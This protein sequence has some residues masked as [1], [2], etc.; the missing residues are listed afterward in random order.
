MSEERIEV[1]GVR[2]GLVDPKATLAELQGFAR[3]RGGWAQLA[4]AGRV[5]GRDHVLA[6]INHARRA[7]DRGTQATDRVE[8]EFLLY[9]SGERQISK[10]IAAAGVRAGRPFVA[11]VCGG[12]DRGEVLARFRWTEDEAVLRPSPAK[13]RALGYTAA[14]I[15]TA[16]DSAADLA[17]ETVARVDLRK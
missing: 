10:A 5:V 1:L 8:L 15:E 12:P 2:T 9:L 3:A 4:D 14:E 16:G 13:V 6:A 7:I 11:V 17:L